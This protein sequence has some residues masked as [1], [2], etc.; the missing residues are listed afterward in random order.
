MALLQVGSP[1]N[2]LTKVIKRTDGFLPTVAAMWTSEACDVNRSFG[3]CTGAIL[4][5]FHQDHRFTHELIKCCGGSSKVVVEMA[6]HRIR[7]NMEQEKPD[8]CDIGCDF[9]FIKSHLKPSSP[10][11]D[12]LIS[13]RGLITA[14]IHML[15]FLCTIADRFPRLKSAM[16]ECLEFIVA[17][18]RAE[19]A[20]QQIKELLNTRFILLLN[21]TDAPSAKDPLFSRFCAIWISLL[22]DVLPRFSVYRRLS[23]KLATIAPNQLHGPPDDLV[24]S[25]LARSSGLIRARG[26]AQED[27]EKRH[28]AVLTCSSVA[29]R[30][31][32]G[33]E[34][35]LLLCSGCSI[36]R[37]CNPS[38]QEHDW[39]E[40]AIFCKDMR[41]SSMSKDGLALSNRELRFIS[42][43]VIHDYSKETDPAREQ[44]GLKYLIPLLV[45]NYDH[46]D[47]LKVKY[48]DASNPSSL[49][50]FSRSAPPNALYEAWSK[51]V[52][53]PE[54]PTAVQ[55]WI[56]RASGHPQIMTAL[57]IDS[58]EGC[59]SPDGL[60]NVLISWVHST[61]SLRDAPRN[62]SDIEK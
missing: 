50:P 45:M 52:Q 3:F 22:G 34:M 4:E 31:P 29:C 33:I 41:L 39:K 18:C 2:E 36:A 1:A 30:K 20:Y 48:A 42:H 55:V 27:F 19:F 35:P 59:Q 9:Y 51:K 26:R 25:K 28:Q 58:H 13:S 57:L 15:E 8:V 60:P 10:I 17:L 54:S 53:R 5:A 47:G 44:E 14:M 46:K 12:A 7:S 11:F 61:S 37:Y 49:S 16:C 21:H 32:E 6:V 38:C 24:R 40:H 56:P 43:L 62:Q 23:Y